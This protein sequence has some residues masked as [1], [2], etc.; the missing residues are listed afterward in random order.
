M[1]VRRGDLEDHETL[2]AYLREIARFPRLTREAEHELGRRARYQQDEAARRQL[3]ES[4]LRFVVSYAKRYRGFG[5]PFLD[6][7]HE[8]N[9]GL[10]E[11]AKRFDPN[12]GVKF[13]TYAVWWVRQGI[14]HT[15][16]GQFLRSRRYE[17][18]L[19][20]LAGRGD[21]DEGSELSSLLSEGAAQPIELIRE[22]LVAQ[23]R[24]ALAE[25]TPKERAV[26]TLRFGLGDDEPRT[27][28]E[29]GDR[30][31]LSGERVRQIESRA[32]EKL[33]RSG[34]AHELRSYLN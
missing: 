14:V 32:K 15:L 33:R 17:L 27:L 28:Q 11:A 26:M 7:I 31:D 6:L 25:L 9:L 29:I 20:E 21:G 23:V 12:R 2:H 1:S 22:A 19:T 3:V 16:S 24:S 8:G 10:I 30:L 4:N 34:K 18:S 5:V 13:I